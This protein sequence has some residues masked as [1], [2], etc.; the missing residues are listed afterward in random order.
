[1]STIYCLNNLY[2]YNVQL[3]LNAFFHNPPTFLGQ[4]VWKPIQNVQ[5]ITLTLLAHFL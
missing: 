2:D 5:K 1:M 4:S 3:K